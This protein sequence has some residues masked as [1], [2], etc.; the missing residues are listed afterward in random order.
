MRQG[1]L[2]CKKNCYALIVIQTLRYYLHFDTHGSYPHKYR[3]QYEDDTDQT[4]KGYFGQFCDISVQTQRNSYDQSCHQN[5]DFT[6]GENR[7]VIQI[8]KS[9]Y[10]FS[11]SIANNNVV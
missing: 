6:F 2:A 5:C 11:Y 3:K 7:A 9:D 8:Q 10:H 4:Q 1:D